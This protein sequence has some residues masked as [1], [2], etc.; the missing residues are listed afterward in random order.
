MN[1][2]DAVDRT[3]R[4][5]RRRAWPHWAGVAGWVA[6]AVVLD[7]MTPVEWRH[8]VMSI[9]AGPVLVSS[10]LVWWCL[11]RL[12][13]ERLKLGDRLWAYPFGR[14]A[15]K[16]LGAIRIG[17]D[18]EEDFGESS[19]PVRLCQVTIE[20]RRRGLRLVASV[21]DAARLREWAGRRCIPFSDPL[22]LSLP[23]TPRR[24][25]DERTA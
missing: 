4:N 20:C 22:D 5:R 13:V 24:G 25:T 2:N 21:C 6:V 1:P 17:P 14:L 18:P 10:V 7:E 12:P 19:Q 11:H 16:D 23:S 3:I 8:A 9:L 15:P